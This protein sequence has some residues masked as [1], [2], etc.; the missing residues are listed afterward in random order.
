[1]HLPQR[2]QIWIYDFS[3]KCAA[4]T[5]I[6]FTLSAYFSHISPYS[7][8][9]SGVPSHFWVL[10]LS[11]LRLC[12]INV[13]LTPVLHTNRART[14]VW[15]LLSLVSSDGYGVPALYIHHLWEPTCSADYVAPQCLSVSAGSNKELAWLRQNFLAQHENWVFS[16]S[17]LV[18][19]Q[20][21]P[22]PGPSILAEKIREVTVS[23]ISFFPPPNLEAFTFDISCASYTCGSYCPPRCWRWS[24]ACLLFAVVLGE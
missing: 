7:H 16:R 22:T 18:A 6:C 14:A 20:P 8:I 5:F 21:A 1:M 23:R 10:R 12:P 17:D 3:K 19:P 15:S 24:V 2:L 13:F 4:R 11:K 9:R